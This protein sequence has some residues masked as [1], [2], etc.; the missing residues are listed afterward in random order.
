MQLCSIKMV[1]ALIT[2]LIIVKHYIFYYLINLLIIV[3]VIPTI[4]KMFILT[5]I[6]KLF[7]H[8]NVYILQQDQC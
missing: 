8:R 2:M 6:L 5:V 4:M 7:S 3:D 1:H